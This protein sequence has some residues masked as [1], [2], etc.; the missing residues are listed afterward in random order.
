V[1]AAPIDAVLHLIA[2]LEGDVEARVSA[3]FLLAPARGA[4]A[5][6][7]ACADRPAA[8]AH[9]SLSSATGRATEERR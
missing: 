2:R 3:P 7:T 4:A 9:S 8:S 6:L 5:L 1:A